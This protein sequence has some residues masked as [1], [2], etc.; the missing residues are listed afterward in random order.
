[1]PRFAWKRAKPSIIT[2]ADQARDARQ[3]EL[4]AR[5]YE[6][7][8]SRNPQRPPIWIQYGHVLKE[9]GRLA[10]AEEAYRTAIAYDRRTAD[11]CLHLGHVLKLQGRQEEAQVAYLQAFARD[12]SYDSVSLELARFGWSEAH[13]SELK[14]MLHSDRTSTPQGQEHKRGGRAAGHRAH[15]PGQPATDASPCGESRSPP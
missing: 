9:S 15:S 8:L 13:F 7:A 3:W 2:L 10:E 12:P 6:T 4:A 11:A 1:M 14:G 5:H